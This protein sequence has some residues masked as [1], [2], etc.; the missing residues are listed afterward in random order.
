MSVLYRDFTEIPSTC[1]ARTDRFDCG[2]N[3]SDGIK[4]PKHSSSSEQ[5]KQH[6]VVPETGQSRATNPQQI[7]LT[8]SLQYSFNWNLDVHKLQTAIHVE[9]VL[10]SVSET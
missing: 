8:G 1:E 2:N 6:V 10:A 9:M 3:D 5:P 7:T 4:F